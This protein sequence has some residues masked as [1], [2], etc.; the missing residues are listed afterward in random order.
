MYY[1]RTEECDAVRHELGYKLCPK[2]KP[3]ENLKELLNQTAD[4]I[5]KEVDRTTP[6]GRAY[7]DR[8]RLEEL[9]L[10]AFTAIDESIA[11]TTIIP[12]NVFGGSTFVHVS[13]LNRMREERDIARGILKQVRSLWER[14]VKM[15]FHPAYL[16]IEEDC[17]AFESIRK[18]LHT[19]SHIVP[20][21]CGLLEENDGLK[22]QLEAA[23][24]D[25]VKLRKRLL[26]LG[27]PIQ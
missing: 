2:C 18:E 25:L 15:N 16:P 1:T 5:E 21:E 6:S 11:E 24:A 22:A 10:E 8:M 17:E 12:L 27:E 19:L 20:A 14:T 9:L 26:G 3:T 4:H 7:F 23:Q 13:Q